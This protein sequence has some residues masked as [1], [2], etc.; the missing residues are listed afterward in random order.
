MSRALLT[1]AR[2]RRLQADQARRDLSEAVAHEQA[3]E[4]TAAQAR[5]QRQREAEA[6]RMS[7]AEGP[8]GPLAGAFATW[9]PASTRQ[10]QA[11][12][13]E[14]ALSRQARAEAAAGLVHRRA[15]LE[16]VEQ[17][18]QA[19]QEVTRRRAD[20]RAQHRL[21]ELARRSGIPATASPPS[22]AAAARPRH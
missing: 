21:D 1:L 11:S 5:A 15:A 18:L 3:A 14:L 20:Q 19:E 8:A 4:T 16:A 7:L 17:L 9:L 6:A 2:L 10:I 22:G 12:D 13:Q